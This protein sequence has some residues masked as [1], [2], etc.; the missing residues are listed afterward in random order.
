MQAGLYSKE[1]TG[2]YDLRTAGQWCVAARQ[3]KRQ[4]R[5]SDKRCSAAWSAQWQGRGGAASPGQG[6]AGGPRA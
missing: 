6:R 1:E 2:S 5:S 3:M 4:Q